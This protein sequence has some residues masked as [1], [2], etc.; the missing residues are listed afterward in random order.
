VLLRRFVAD[1]RAVLFATDSFWEGVDVRGDALRC[2]IIPRLPF[3]VPTEPIEQA[4]VE[5]LKAQGRNPFAEHSLPQAVVKLKQGFGRLIR[6]RRDRGCV[7]I[8]DSRLARK[9]YGQVFLRSLPPARQ[10]IAPAH[11]VFHAMRDFFSTEAA[12][13]VRPGA[14]RKSQ[15]P[16][17]T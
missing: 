11:Q 14:S 16:N 2:V 10:V 9:H 5:R 17:P 6:T 4:R 13:R 3:T 7:L 8:L 1:P 15:I 12:T